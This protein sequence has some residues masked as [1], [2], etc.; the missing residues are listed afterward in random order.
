MTPIRN[1]KA[2]ASLVDL[3]LA[4]RGLAPE[5]TTAPAKASDDR[6]QTYSFALNFFAAVAIAAIALSLLILMPGLST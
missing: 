2:T 3:A 1:S 4:R 6:I 5:S